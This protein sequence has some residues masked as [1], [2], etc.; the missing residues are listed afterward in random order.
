[1]PTAMYSTI[2]SLRNYAAISLQVP[3]IL[4]ILLG[5]AR[6]NLN[7]TVPLNSGTSVQCMTKSLNS[8][9]EAEIRKHTGLTIVLNCYTE[10]NS[11]DTVKCTSLINAKLKFK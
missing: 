9:S 4:S 8:D 11:S 7:P 10:T 1:M 2:T 5:M 3:S 6:F